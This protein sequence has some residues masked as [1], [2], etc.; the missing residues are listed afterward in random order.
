MLAVIP[1]GAK[2][3]SA[4]THNTSPAGRFRDAAAGEAGGGGRYPSTSA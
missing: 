1:I 2:E 3:N 4:T